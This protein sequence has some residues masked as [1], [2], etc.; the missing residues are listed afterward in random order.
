M[1]QLG[2]SHANGRFTIPNVAPG[3]YKVFSWE[4]L[5]G[6]DVNP[7][8]PDV[9]EKYEPQGKSI[10]VAEASSQNV[11]VRLIPAP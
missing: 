7:F 3:E 10:R 2:G 1:M 6:L 9:L 4:A 8:D 11:D 5:D